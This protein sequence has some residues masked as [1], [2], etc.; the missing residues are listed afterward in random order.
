M[1][2]QSSQR[3]SELRVQTFRNY[4]NQ[5]FSNL[6][7]LAGD[8]NWKLLAVTNGNAVEDAVLT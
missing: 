5:S 4:A 8:H 2:H 3:P 6:K 1:R 7:C